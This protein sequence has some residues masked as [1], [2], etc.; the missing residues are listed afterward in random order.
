MNDLDRFININLRIYKWLSW[1]FNINFILLRMR[2]L[3]YKV[4]FKKNIHILRMWYY[5][6]L[7][8]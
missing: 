3:I 2:F 1:Y 5:K 7:G 4:R 6:M 8:K